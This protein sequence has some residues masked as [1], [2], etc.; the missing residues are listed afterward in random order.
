MET[1]DCI[2]KKAQIRLF[3]PNKPV[4]RHTLLKILDAGRWAPSSGNIQNW[5]FIVVND[6]EKKKIIANATL[7]A[8]LVN[9][10]PMAIVV[11]SLT[12]D[13]ERDYGKRGKELYAIQNTAAA[14][15]NILLAAHDLGLGATWIYAFAEPKIRKALEIRGYADIHAI[16]LIG[17]PDT[18][19]KRPVGERRTQL[20]R[21]VWFNMWKGRGAE[22]F[23]PIS[24]HLKKIKEKLKRK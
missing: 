12:E 15:Q 13:V 4:D 8:E 19:T 7:Q 23:W 16:V 1:L 9:S 11:C 3:N 5:K 21:L 10:A 18:A 6:P 2:K 14:I 17:Y 24:K 20:A 22:S